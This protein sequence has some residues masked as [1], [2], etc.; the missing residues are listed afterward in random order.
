M[1]ILVTGAEGQVGWECRR[2]LQTLGTVSAIDVQDC[3]L[4]DAVAVRAMLRALDPDLIVNPAAFTAVDRAESQPELAQVV[5]ALAPTLLADEARLRGVAMIHLSTDY[6]FDGTL[7]RPYTEDDTPNPQSVYGRTKLAGERGVLDSGAAAIVLR[8]SWVYAARAQNFVK[9]MLQLARERAELRVVN[10]QFGAPTWAR[11]LAEGIAAIVGRAGHDRASIAQS[12]AQRGGVF[13]MTAGGQTT[14]FRFVEHIMANVTD[15]KR[16]L[17]S[18]VPISTADY[19]TA[20]RRPPYS[21][22]NCARLAQQWGVAL[23]PWEEA[24]AMAFGEPQ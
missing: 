19:P 6:V 16:T 22:L 10:D 18:I 23:P 15:A 14:W 7:S 2:S 24:F 21:V 4:T 8:T 5:N 3:D 17:K 20:A 12:F 1:R 9:T 13:H 11:S